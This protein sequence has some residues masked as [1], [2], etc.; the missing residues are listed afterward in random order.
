M[1][2]FHKR[3]VRSAEGTW[4]IHGQGGGHIFQEGTCSA[5]LYRAG[6]LFA[7]QLPTRQPDQPRFW[8]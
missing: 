3:G 4:A 6:G 5:T 1:D 2:S 7:D 8:I